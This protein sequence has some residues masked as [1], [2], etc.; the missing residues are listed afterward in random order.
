MTD[1]STSNAS[2]QDAS[3]VPPLNVGIEDAARILCVSVSTLNRWRANGEGPDYVR[4]GGRVLY[5]VDS[6]RSFCDARVVH[7]GGGAR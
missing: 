7:M 4:L 1:D 2:C 5:P 3:M 6:L